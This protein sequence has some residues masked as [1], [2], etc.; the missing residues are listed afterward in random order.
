[1][2]KKRPLFLFLMPSQAAAAAVRLAQLQR[3]GRWEALPDLAA[4]TVPSVEIHPI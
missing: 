2:H 1:L 4:E 3:P